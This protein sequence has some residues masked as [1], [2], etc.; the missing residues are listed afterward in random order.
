M[1]PIAIKKS[2]SK[3]SNK[4]SQ[5]D[6][7]HTFPKVLKEFKNDI[8]IP[9]YSTSHILKKNTDNEIVNIFPSIISKKTYIKTK[10]STSLGSPVYDFI[11]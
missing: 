7:T 6:F 1:N 2:N 9:G 8:Y 11:I 4:I 5:N 3:K 10:L